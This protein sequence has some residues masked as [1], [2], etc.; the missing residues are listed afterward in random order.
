[1]TWSWVFVG[2]DG[3]KLVPGGVAEDQ[4]F[5]SQSDAETWLGEE[6]RELAASGVS[7]AILRE[8]DREVYGPMPLSVGP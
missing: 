6:W 4:T 8:A 3:S 5:P 1:M 7:G 2:A